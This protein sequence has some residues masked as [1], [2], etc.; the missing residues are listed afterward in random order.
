MKG[1]RQIRTYLI[2]NAR[3]YGPKIFGLDLKADYY[4]TEHDRST[5]PV[6]V[7]LLKNPKKPQEP[8]PMYPRV[9]FTDYKV[10]DKE[11]FGSTA[12]LNVSEFPIHRPY[13]SR[14]LSRS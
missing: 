5:V 7:D 14:K 10:V 11:L 9:L 1:V 3:K 2:D 4:S 6:F 8:Y 12:I 13:L